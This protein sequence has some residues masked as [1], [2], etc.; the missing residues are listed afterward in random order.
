VQY[1]QWRKSRGS[2]E[3]FHGAVVDH[4]GNEQTREFREVAQVGAAL[5]RLDEVV[6][7]SVRPDVAVVQD[8]ENEW[9]LNAGARVYLGENVKYREECLAHYRPFWEAGV[10]VDVIDQTCD[11]DR[12]K[13]VAIPMAYMLRPGFADRLTRYIERGGVAVM[14]YWSGVVDETDLCVLGGVPGQGLRT[15]FGV[16]EE[17]SQSYFPHE[18]VGLT[19]VPDNCLG[20]SGTYTAV[21][22]CSVIHAEGAEVLA[23]YADQYFAGGPALTVNRCGRGLAYYLASRNE[24]RFLSDF[25]GRLIADLSLTRAL[26]TALPAGVTA[27]IRT[28]GSV[29]YLFL[30]NFDNQPHNVALDGAYLDMLTESRVTGTVTLAGYGVM[31]LQVRMDGQ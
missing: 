31:V 25:Y 11:L 30:M 12:Y 2:V 29:R 16:W 5:A 24:P 26:N 28:D 27:Q 15:V 1:F 3:K 4:V 23:T 21:D 6:G 14:T 22:T 18:S 9:A 20:L 19:M 17:E 13:L 7:T 10:P 8:W